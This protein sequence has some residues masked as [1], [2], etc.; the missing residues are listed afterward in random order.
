[1][2]LLPEET[3]WQT[4]VKRLETDARL[5]TY[6]KKVFEGNRQ[7]YTD[8]PYIVMEWDGGDEKKVAMPKQ[9]MNKMIIII[10]GVI[11]IKGRPDTQ[12]V[13]DDQ[14]VGI[15]RLKHDIMRAFEGSDMRYNDQVISTEIRVLPTRL[16]DNTLREVNLELTVSFR[17]QTSESR[18]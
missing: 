13:G 15:L 17:Y 16:I 10:R 1:M 5:G 4:I 8:A 3:V 18:T 7:A 9:I 2:T 14:Q 6:I 12:I 11:D